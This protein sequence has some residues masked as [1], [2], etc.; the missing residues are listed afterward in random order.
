VCNHIFYPP[1]TDEESR[2]EGEDMPFLSYATSRGCNQEVEEDIN[3][4]SLKRN[5]VN[6]I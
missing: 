5:M 1:K 4:S 2:I 6:H 3:D